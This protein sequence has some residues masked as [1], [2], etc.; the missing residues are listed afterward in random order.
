M[1]SETSLAAGRLSRRG[2]VAV[3]GAA[4][5]AAALA[6][7]SAGGTTNVSG[8]LKFWDMQWGNPAAEY[9][10]F[11]KQNTIAFKPA[12]GLPKATYQ[13]VQWSNF[14]QTFSSAIASKTGPA[15]ST[16]GGFQAFQ[17]AKQGSIAYADDLLGQMKK[18]G[19][20]DDF[21]PGTLE[22]MKTKD[23][24][25]AIPWNLDVI[26]L[27]YRKSA[28]DAVGATAPTT[29]D[30]YLSVAEKLAKKGTY[31]F[32]VG[33]GPDNSYG[34]ESM[35]ALMINNGGG[36]FDSDGKLDLVTDRNIEAMDFVLELG[37][38]GAIDPGSISY[39]NA[40]YLDRFKSG[41]F[42]MGWSDS[43]LDTTVDAV[44]DL[45][46]GQPL[47]APHGDKGTVM[48]INN[49][50]MYTNT[51][52]QADSEG[53]VT[54]YMKTLHK[55]FDKKLI[56]EIP[57]L[58]SIVNSATFQSDKQQVALAKLWQPIAKTIA[59]KSVPLT[60]SLATIDGSQEAIDFTQTMLAGKTDSKTALATFETAIKAALA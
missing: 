11:M 32:G 44:G 7:C 15:V 18:N 34:P 4:A 23:G 14:V 5:V 45:L 13:S 47:T 57:A 46:V 20:Y 60:S 26:A 30:E 31:A 21:L 29:W 9:A 43:Y 55:V 6:A 36:L 28:L 27:W 41:K 38:M 49:I 42:S 25:A 54:Y 19:M 8:T 1:N 16:G 40:D 51:P 10:S 39:S 58:K 48:Y 52:S 24:Y 50:M 37:K 12:T 33:G 56:A 22:A 3:T 53:F 35:Y 59:A 17:F 2:F